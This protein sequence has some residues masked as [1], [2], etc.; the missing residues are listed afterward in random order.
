M[1]TSH[2]SLPSRHLAAA[3]ASAQLERDLSAFDSPKFL[4]TG[5]QLITYR[6]GAM[7]EGVG[8]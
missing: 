4:V 3:T 8:T 5:T 2:K 7:G 6:K 1:R